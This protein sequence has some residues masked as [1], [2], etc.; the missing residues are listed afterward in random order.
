MRKVVAWIHRYLGLSLGGLLLISG[1]TGSIIVFN[2]DIDATLNAGLFQV[3][4]REARRS[5]DDILQNVRAAVPFKDAGFVF[6]PQSPD[7]A[8]EV[9]FRDTDLRAYA[10]PYTGELLGTRNAKSSL[11]GFLVDL[12]IHLLSGETGERV[13]GWAGLGGIVVSA[14]GLW[15][16]WPKRGRWKQAL[17]IK[18]EAAPGRLWLDVHKLVGALTFVLFVLTATTGAA[19]ALYELITEPVL[20]ALTGEGAR[21]SA[22]KSRSSSG[23]AAPVS[24]MLDQAA[25]L[26]PGAQITRITL[27]AKPNAAVAVRMRLEG[28]I[29]QFGRTFIWFDQ[30]DGSVLRVDNALLANRATRIQSW[31]YP[32]HTGVY[33]GL[34]TRLLQV[35]VGLSLSLLTLSGAWLWYRSYSAR[36]NAAKRLKALKTLPERM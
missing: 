34:A 12:H 13:V 31:L 22:P 16:W 5:I 7:L 1:L 23:A 11:M 6:L 20:I 26:F 36:S 33:G 30:Y 15:L 25:L 32:L 35:M 19:L 8:L 18:W 28:E 14:L 21:K 29:H 2:K 9:W 24:P 27:P 10:D 4:P 17:Q 3:Q